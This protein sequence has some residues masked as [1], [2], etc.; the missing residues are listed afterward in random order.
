MKLKTLKTLL[1]TVL[2]SSF[3][4]IAACSDDE[5]T[6]ACTGCESDAPWSVLGGGTCYTTQAECEDVEGDCERCD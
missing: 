1:L 2:F 5:E 4:W 3:V 6:L